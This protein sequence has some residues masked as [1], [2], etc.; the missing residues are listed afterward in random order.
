MNQ[1]T[2]HDNAMKKKKRGED[3][4]LG[5]THMQKQLHPH[6]NLMHTEKPQTTK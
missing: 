5:K 2:D 3:S 6:K 4:Q 1:V